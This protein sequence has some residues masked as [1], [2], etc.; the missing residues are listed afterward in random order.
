MAA[1]ISKKLRHLAGLD[2]PGGG[3][4][5]VRDGIA[6]VG[7][8]KPPHGTSIIDVTDPANPK[9]I[10]SLDVGSPWSHTHKV[11]VAGDL[12]ITNVEQDRRH[13]IR[14]GE[15]IPEVEKRLAGKLGRPPTQGETAADMG[16][17]PEELSDMQAAVA[18]G[19]NEGGF[20]VWDISRPSE[21]KLLSYV[22]THGF[23]VHRFD[24]DERYAYI[25]TEMAGYVGNILVIYDLANPENIAEVSRWWLPGQHLA[26]G[27]TPT[28]KGYG[29]RLHHAMRF[30]DQLWAAVW[31][32]GFRVIDI[33][34]IASPKTIGSYNYHPW[35]V[36]P[37]HTILPAARQF[38]GR[39]IA[40]AADEEHDHRHGQPHA[41]LWVFDVSD[42]DQITPLATFHVSEMDSPWSRAEGRFG[43]HQFQEHID[44]DKV[45]CAWFAGG[46]RVVDIAVPEEPREDAFFMPEPRP[47]FASPQ[48]NDVDIDACGLVY[49]ID[50]NNGFDILEYTA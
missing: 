9:V 19:Y 30:G 17:T 50:R 42:L 24:M 26:G 34:D 36:E 47:G 40:L 48:T 39:T 13:F 5:M 21:P 28:W 2:I 23:G 1:L 31:H 4:V 20:K 32:A 6:Y 35:V 38:D 12:M 33:S 10:A 16:V 49:L 22:R 7:H 44:D 29:H 8:M 25:S 27:E 14:R 18:R 15:R 11:R 43:L 45:F 37:T 41:G 46:L 3:Q